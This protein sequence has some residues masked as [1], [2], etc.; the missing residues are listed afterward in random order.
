LTKLLDPPFSK[1]SHRQP[2]LLN[3]G[4]ELFRAR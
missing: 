1:P 4:T 2:E 3:S